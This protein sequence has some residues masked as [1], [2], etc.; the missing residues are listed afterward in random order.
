MQYR[1]WLL[2]PEPISESAFQDLL[3]SL[4]AIASV[5]KPDSAEEYHPPVCELLL[6]SE[7]ALRELKSS[8]QRVVNIAGFDCLI[9]AAD[10][11]VIEP[12]LLIM[13]MDSTLVQAETIDQI[14]KYAGVMAEVSAITE[15][16][17]RGELDF[18][19]SL[20]RRVAMLEGISKSQ[21]E[22]VHNALPLTDGAEELIRA[23]SE[24]DC[25]TVL[26]SGGFTYFAQPI[27]DRIGIREVHA[28]HL[29]FANEHLT[30]RVTG[31]IV[32]ADYKRRTL[33]DLIAARGLDRRQTI[34]IGDGAN[35]LLMLG[36]AGT[37]IAFHG[38]PKVQAESSVAINIYGLNAV[39]WWLGW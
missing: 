14:A 8:I 4:S 1:L 29:E 13:D 21:L 7:L 23:A 33:D 39:N 9:K 20:K 34:A 2:R 31:E 11:V 32:D 10:E 3:S 28:N 24:H 38:K 19:Q 18:T 6:Q 30:G 35:D 36:A 17:M 15:A 37:G 16:A 26:V 25:H 27:A 5:A 22:G 12:Q